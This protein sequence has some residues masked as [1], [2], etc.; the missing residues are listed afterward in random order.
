MEYL[1]LIGIAVIVIGFAAKLRVTVIVLVAGLATG[2][3]AQVVHGPAAP[4]VLDT[5]GRAFTANRLITL[6]VLALP[7]IGLC[8]RHGLQEQSRRVIGRLRAA[9]VGRLQL[10]Y[11]LVRI[12]VVALGIRLGSGH[13]SFSRPLI[14]PMAL[15]TAGLADASRA[16]RDDAAALATDRVK[17]ACGASENYANFFGQNLFPGAAGVLIVVRTLEANGHAVDAVDVSLATLP[18]AIASLVLGALQYR[19]FDRWLA[20]RRNGEAK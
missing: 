9:T 7:A 8:E 17:A 20:R 10:A 5:L 4:G 15:G 13:V 14:V 2:L 16:P 1:R 18:I 6:F 3:A 12:G 19:L 11:H